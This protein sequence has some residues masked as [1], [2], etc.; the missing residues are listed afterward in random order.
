MEEPVDRHDISPR[1]FPWMSCGGN[2][3][4]RSTTVSA[5]PGEG[6]NMQGEATPRIPDL[7]QLITR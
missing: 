4:T 2:L 3:R 7:G 1:Y 5:Q 6:S